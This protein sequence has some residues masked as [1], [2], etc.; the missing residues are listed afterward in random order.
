V[1][2]ITSQPFYLWEELMHP[3]D[4]SLG[5]PLSWSGWLWEIKSVAT[6]GT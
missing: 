6:V 2:N 1:V 5:V 4:R 3:L